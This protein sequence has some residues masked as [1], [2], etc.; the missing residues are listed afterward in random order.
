MRT[1]KPIWWSAIFL[2]LGACTGLP[3]NVRPVA[4]F[5]ANRYL[6]TWYE[7]A[8]LDHSFERGLDSVTATYRLRED[9]GITVL[10]R[11]RN[12]ARKEWKQAEGR[13]YLVGDPAVGHLKVSFFGPFYSSYVI[14]DLSEDYQTAY[15]A[16]FNH[17]YLWL[18]ARRPQLSDAEKS[19]FIR[20]A[21]DAGFDLDQLIWVEQPPAN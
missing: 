18:L 8:R 7:I 10:N 14:F 20:A 9:G 17:D 16:G 13:A 5:D 6:G 2:M 3:E 12:A 21:R 1:M 4:G 19:R 15:V 11:G